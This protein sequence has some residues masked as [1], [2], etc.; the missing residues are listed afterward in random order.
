MIKVV[1]SQMLKAEETIRRAKAQASG[2]IGEF[3]FDSLANM[4][5]DENYKVMSDVVLKSGTGK[6]TAQIDQIIV[7]IYGIIVV[8]IKTYKGYI[9]GSN[10]DRWIQA[11]G[12]RKNTFYNPIMQN[13]KHINVIQNI[14]KLPDE[15]FKML[16]VF[17]GEAKFGT[18]MPE[19]IVRGGKEYLTYIK[20]QK[21][22]LFDDYAVSEAV[23]MI[24]S[25]RLSNEEHQE[26][27]NRLKAKYGDNEKNK[28]PVCPKCKKK[29]V[30]RTA[31]KGNYRGEKFWGCVNYPKCRFVVNMKM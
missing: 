27:M 19:Y 5:L 6:G 20:N 29:M 18:K 14:L 26:Y 12:R 16:I 7:S 2:R 23:K 28:A 30:M 10:G 15:K 9:F 31:K 22:P 13:C 17:S 25:H 1:L 4:Y 8:E 24:K 21:T 3:V 11:L